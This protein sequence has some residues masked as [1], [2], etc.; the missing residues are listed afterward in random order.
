MNSLAMLRIYSEY[1]K[2][3]RQV[4]SR[5]GDS[6][7]NEWNE[8]DRSYYVV[9]A[10]DEGRGRVDI[11][12]TVAEGPLIPRERIRTELF[13]VI[14]YCDAKGNLELVGP[15]IGGTEL[16]LAGEA[17]RPEGQASQ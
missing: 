9:V 17:I 7:D 6:N 11:I 15:E 16:S 8:G 2:H 5:H 4:S 14:A 10:G 3:E 13:R 1:G 12:P